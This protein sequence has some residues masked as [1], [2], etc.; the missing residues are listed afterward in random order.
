MSFRYRLRQAEMQVLDGSPCRSRPMGDALAV[1]HSNHISVKSLNTYGTT[2]C[3]SPV[4][5]FS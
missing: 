1:S 2:P 5:S 3:G 4:A